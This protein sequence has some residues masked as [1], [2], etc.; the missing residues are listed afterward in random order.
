MPKTQIDYIRGQ[1]YVTRNGERKPLEV[2]IGKDESWFT[3]KDG[4]FLE[5]ESDSYIVHIQEYGRPSGTN[6]IGVGPDSK[7]VMKIS[8]GVIDQIDLEHGQLTL[9]ANMPVAT[10]VA[11]VKCAGEESQYADETLSVIRVANEQL[12]VANLGGAPLK[13]MNNTT[14][15][16]LSVTANT[17]GDYVFEQATLTSDGT[18]L[19]EITPQ[20]KSI[21]NKIEDELATEKRDKFTKAMGADNAGKRYVEEMQKMI[22]DMRQDIEELEREGGAPKELKK[23]VKKLEMQLSDAK[24][25]LREK[26]MQEQQKRAKKKEHDEWEK[27]FSAREKQFEKD[28]EK[29]AAEVDSQ[30]A[31]AAAD[32]MTDLERKIQQAGAGIATEEDSGASDS[33]LSELEKKIQ[34]AGKE[35]DEDE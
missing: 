29:M 23:G 10:S 1:A 12:E 33:D 8:G 11:T 25:E 30:S 19:D 32:N 9:A 15:E 27:K 5:T 14:R 18:E 4:D 24:K 31:G 2:N 22:A 34:A 20:M 7:L 13:V 35:L 3:L 26:E 17:A 6:R 21:F 28:L 16:I